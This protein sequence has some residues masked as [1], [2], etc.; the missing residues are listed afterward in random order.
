MTDDAFALRM[1]TVYHY[2]TA[3]FVVLLSVWCL[4]RIIILVG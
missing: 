4:R 1:G 2:H 3:T